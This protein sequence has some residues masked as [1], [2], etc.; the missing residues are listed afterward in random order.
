MPR[1]SLSQS[2]LCELGLKHEQPCPDARDIADYA[3]RIK[4]TYAH[5]Y[6]VYEPSHLF[7]IE[8]LCVSVSKLDQNVLVPTL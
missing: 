3:P 7:R 6:V 5:D 4:K 2:S 1:A 8:L